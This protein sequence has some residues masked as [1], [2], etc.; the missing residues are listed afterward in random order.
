[1]GARD[2]LLLGARGPLAV[3]VELRLEALERVD[4]LLVLVAQSFGLVNVL[5]L[6]RVGVLDLVR[7]YAFLASSSSSSMTS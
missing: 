3:V 1:V 2:Q 6:L 4:Q 7:H 5:D